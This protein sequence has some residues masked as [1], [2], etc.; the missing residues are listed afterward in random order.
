MCDSKQ[1]RSSQLRR[2]NERAKMPDVADLMRDRHKPDHV[3]GITLDTLLH[4][5]FAARPRSERLTNSSLALADTRAKRGCGTRQGPWQVL[6]S[7]WS[8]CADQIIDPH[9]Q[10]RPLLSPSC[11]TVHL[12]CPALNTS[13]KLYLSF[14]DPHC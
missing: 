10:L 6:A 11:L 14:T 2:R 1:F 4:D 8:I 9:V 12:H 13:L 7:Y 3:T 5:R